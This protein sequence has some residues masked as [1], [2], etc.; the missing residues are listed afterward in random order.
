VSSANLLK[1]HSIPSSRSLIKCYTE[2]APKLSPGEHHLFLSTS[3]VYLH[4]PPLYSIYNH[5]IT[6]KEVINYYFYAAVV[7]GET[8]GLK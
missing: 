6:E 3:W 7:C 2:L 8:L 1:E 4:S 5:Y